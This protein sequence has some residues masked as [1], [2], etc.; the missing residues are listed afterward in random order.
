MHTNHGNGLVFACNELLD[1]GVAEVH[2]RL[3]DK[4]NP[5]VQAREKCVEVF[6]P[7]IGQQITGFTAVHEVRRAPLWAIR[8][9]SDIQAEH[10]SFR[11]FGLLC[12]KVEIPSATFKN[13][14]VHPSSISAA[15]RL[16]IPI[17]SYLIQESSN[18][19]R[20]YTSANLRS[21]KSIR[22]SSG[23]MDSPRLPSEVSGLWFEYYDSP[24]SIVGQWLSESTAMSLERGESITGISI[25]LSN[26]RKSFSEKYY[27][28][29]VVCVSILTS[30]RTLSYPDRNPLPAEEC[31]ILRFEDNCLEGLASEPLSCLTNSFLKMK[32]ADLTHRLLSSGSSMTHGTFHGFSKAP[33]RPARKSSTGIRFN[34]PRR[35]RGGLRSRY[36][37][38]EPP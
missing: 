26:S 6:H 32:N 29:R 8:W 3:S 1:S 36:S 33:N 34:S 22:F 12:E 28:G 11:A 23:R 31:T 30:L 7:P 16:S 4:P 19:C 5:F 13:E 2:P 18:G 9:L 15:V 27:T 37:G 35:V 38:R 20:A 14:T 24:P 10:G 21:V 17:G 25:W